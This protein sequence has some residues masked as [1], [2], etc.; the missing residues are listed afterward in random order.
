MSWNGKRVLV[1]GAHGF[2]GS[3]VVRGL[4]DHGAAEVVGLDR[5]GI[6]PT[7]VALKNSAHVVSG[8]D[9]TDPDYVPALEEMLQET[10]VL[11]HLAGMVSVDR[12]E[13]TPLTALRDNVMATGVL[14][15]IARQT[16]TAAV[17]AS[18]DRVYGVI[19]GPSAL[20]TDPLHP[21]DVYGATKAAADLLVVQA[22]RAGYKVATLRHVNAYGPADPH[23]DHLIP[24]TIRAMLEGQEP[25]IRSDGSPCKSYLY[26]ADVVEAYLTLGLETFQGRS[27]GAYNCAPYDFHAVRGV[28]GII[29]ETV[30]YHSPVTFQGTDQRQTNYCE[31]LNAQKL[32]DLGWGP[33]VTF[34]EG[35]KRTVEW[36][37]ER[38]TWPL[39]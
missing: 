9:V 3:H 29:A 21:V 26:I 25:H 35:I 17:F 19:P 33:Q 10:D 14:L 12:C 23:M 39:S 32:R 2:I 28:V 1:T 24:G 37:A 16:Q 11:F 20:E 22:A 13:E 4:L 31:R 27:T 6:S 38:P 15:E 8:V 18:S 30:G 36:Y 5:F 7:W 34:R